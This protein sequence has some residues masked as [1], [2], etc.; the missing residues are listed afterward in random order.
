MKHCVSLARQSCDDTVGPAIVIVI[1]KYHAHARKGP[2]I[3]IER[4]ARFQP[5]LAECAVAVVVKQILLHAVVG[6]ID[7]RESIAIVVGE[8]HAQTMT[9]LGG[10][11]RTLAHVFKSAVSAIV[12]ENVG[13]PGKFSRRTISVIVPAAVF[14][15]PRVPIHVAR[16]K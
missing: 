1:L 2:S 8:G 15:M 6:Y 12:I 7:V 9:F 16:D 3:Q 14:A 11:S 5:D 4:C 13:G 10:D